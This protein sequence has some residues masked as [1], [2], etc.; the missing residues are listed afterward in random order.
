MHR[1]AELVAPGGAVMVTLRHG[2]VPRGR[3]MF[4][5][6]DEETI[7]LARS[8]G[9]KVEVHERDSDLMGRAEVQWSSLG[10]RKPANP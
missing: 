7:E 3:H 2:P 10:F 8:C 6:G 9:L 5:V 1:V 4:D